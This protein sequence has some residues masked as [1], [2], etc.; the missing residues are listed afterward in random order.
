M[1][2]I[3]RTY[4]VSDRKIIGEYRARTMIQLYNLKLADFIDGEE[5][6][7]GG[8]PPPAKGKGKAPTGPEGA[9]ILIEV[10]IDEFN[11]FV[12]ANLEAD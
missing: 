12:K 5:E 2:F 6:P 1:R 7:A 10:T 4:R 9:S 11:E 3:F 8:A